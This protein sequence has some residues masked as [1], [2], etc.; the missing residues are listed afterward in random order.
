MAVSIRG[1]F[2]KGLKISSSSGGTYFILDHF[3]GTGNIGDHTGDSGGTWSDVDV[4]YT[5][6]IVSN[7]EN[8]VTVGLPIPATPAFQ[9]GLEVTLAIKNGSRLIA[10]ARAYDTSGGG[11][12]TSDDNGVTWIKRYNQKT[13][14][15]GYPPK[16]I[17]INI[18]GNNLF[19]TTDVTGEGFRS[20]NN[21]T[22]WS[23]IDI[24]SSYAV[25]NGYNLGRMGTDG[26]T[27]FLTAGYVQDPNIPFFT[28]IDNGLNWAPTDNDAIYPRYDVAPSYV[29][30]EYSFGQYYTFDNQNFVMYTSPDAAS[31]NWTA[32]EIDLTINPELAGHYG[33][34]AL[35]GLLTV[36]VT[37]PG[38]GYVDGT[39][40]NVPLT[41]AVYGV[42]A[43]ATIVVSGGAVTSVTVTT[44]GTNYQSNPFNP[45]NP[46]S[47]ILSANNADLGGS[48]SGFT[49]TVLTSEF[50][51]VT[52]N[53]VWQLS[54]DTWIISVPVDY[55]GGTNYG[56]WRLSVTTSGSPGSPGKISGVQI[57]DIQDDAQFSGYAPEIDT[58]GS[59]ILISGNLFLSKGQGYTNTYLTTAAD[60]STAASNNQMAYTFTPY[61]WYTGLWLAT[62]FP[63]YMFYDGTTLALSP[64]SNTTVG[65]QTITIGTGTPHGAPPA[66]IPVIQTVELSGGQAQ[67]QSS[68][69]YGMYMLSS[70]VPPAGNF[71]VELDI[72][73]T[74]TAYNY[75]IILMPVQGS[76]QYGPQLIAF[77]D[78]TGYTPYDKYTTSMSL[79]A[80]DGEAVSLI[81]LNGSLQKTTGVGTN[82]IH[83]LRLEVTNS[84]QTFTSFFDGVQQD[85]QIFLVNGVE[86][87]N[88]TSVGTGYTSGTYL[89]VPLTGGTGTGARADFVMSF[90]SIGVINSVDTGTGYGDGFYYDVVLTGGT[91]SGATANFQVSTGNV[92]SVAMQ[93]A[94]D[95]YTAGDHLSVNN[96]DF[97]GTGSGFDL[98]VVNI[99]ED[100]TLNITDHGS[101]YNVADVMSVLSS[102]VGGTGS[103]FTASPQP[104]Q[105]PVIDSFMIFYQPGTDFS[106]TALLDLRG[107]SL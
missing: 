107:G 56:L 13:N 32:Y 26:T 42:G 55:S 58:Q 101:G 83:T 79:I 41:G 20:T 8:F 36:S 21:G 85:Q 97:G 92:V 45:G 70:L 105:M 68:Y 72:D 98:L 44:P 50:A 82:G 30:T 24:F 57:S 64:S 46:P 47:D 31:N 16:Y 52:V 54:A 34:S 6:Y 18:D 67:M 7:P 22:T 12:F 49:A 95:G 80:E 11:F 38:S 39:Y 61:E 66:A 29:G 4:G 23:V 33:G 73:M 106:K 89:D 59:G 27:I 62:V 77:F 104:G 90:G 48:G 2:L 86:Y 15:A 88:I 78:S 1:A 71:Y 65:D 91:G 87:F 94:G 25:S 63:G 75:N 103:G 35:G 10:A 84:N 76:T 37:T 74:I 19:V 100:I 81:P 43:E 102:N 60:P 53:N 69:Q 93:T 99:N 3:N 96:I 28:S 40:T 5:Q 17:D 14:S 51:G 9:I